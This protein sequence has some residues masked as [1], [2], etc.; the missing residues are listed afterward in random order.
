MKKF[1]LLICLFISFQLFSQGK[2]SLTHDD[3][4]KWNRVTA[5]SISNDGNLI[6]Y[7]FRPNTGR[8]DSSVEIYNRKTSNFF[9]SN[10]GSSPIISHE[11]SYVFFKKNPP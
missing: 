10:Y 8:G 11:G 2:R 7:Q 3:Y 4:D 1:T 6:S 9:K 5:V